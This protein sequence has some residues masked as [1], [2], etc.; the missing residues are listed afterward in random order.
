MP[1]NEKVAKDRAEAKRLCELWRKLTTQDIEEY[2]DTLSLDEVD[3][4][5]ELFASVSR[6]I[7]CE[8]D[9]RD[10]LRERNIWREEELS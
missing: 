9:R 8:I 1:L 10:H 4:V 7:Q 3:E 6:E 2:L 5:I